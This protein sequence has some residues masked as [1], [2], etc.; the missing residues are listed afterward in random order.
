MDDRVTT[1][2]KLTYR[3]Q[4]EKFFGPG[5]AELLEKVEQE[6]SVKEACRSMGLS[7]SKGR[8]ILRRAEEWIGFPLL[9]I[10]HGGTGGGASTLT[11]EGKETLEA[12]RRLEDEVSRFAEKRFRE[13]VRKGK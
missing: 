4:G 11:Q 8:A 12:Y 3:A 9:C 10:K 13:S 6:G 1:V 7:Y 5:V 2:V